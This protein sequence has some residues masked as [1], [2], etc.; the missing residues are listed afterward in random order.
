MNPIAK[1]TYRAFQTVFKLAIPLLPYRTPEVLERVSQLP[2][3]LKENGIRRVLIV[4]DGFLHLSGMLDPLKKALEDHGIFFTVYDET[5]PNPTV[6]NVEAAR[7][8]YI[9]ECCQGLIGFGGGSAIDCAKAVGA[10]I[11]RPRKPIC[12]MRC[13]K[14]QL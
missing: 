2:A 9:Q 11:A 1:F 4:T 13:M 3:I 5:V 8:R 12:K 6:W 10:R 14:R 7:E